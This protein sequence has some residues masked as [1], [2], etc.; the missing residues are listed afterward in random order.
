M[1]TLLLQAKFAFTSSI[2]TL[3]DYGIYLFAVDYLFSPVISNVIS[4]P[5][6]ILVNFILQKKYI[7]SLNRKVSHIFILSISFSAIGFLISTL[8]IYILT[9]VAFFPSNQYISKFIAT[10]IVFFYNFYTKRYAFENFKT[11]CG[12][13][14]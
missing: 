13:F 9:Q 5:T 2:A 10:G 3:I 7:F 14:P 6:G 8:L 4:Y 1:N 11:A 12:E